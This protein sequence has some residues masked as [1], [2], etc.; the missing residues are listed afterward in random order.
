[1]IYATL[2]EAKAQFLR[3]KGIPNISYIDD[4]WVG[5]SM[6]SRKS[7]VQQQWVAA[8]NALQFAVTVSFLCGYYLAE[9]KCVLAP[10]QTLRYLGIICDSRRAVFFSN[11]SR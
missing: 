11:T 6:N 3:S 2:S 5:N 8:E 7:S 10:T 4:A 9:T 1:M